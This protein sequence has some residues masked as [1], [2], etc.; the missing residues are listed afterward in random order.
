LPSC[1]VTSRLQAS[2]QSSGQT[3]EMECSEDGE[4]FKAIPTV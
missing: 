1:T 2:G 4:V 3:V